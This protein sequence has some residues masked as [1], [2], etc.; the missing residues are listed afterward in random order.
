MSFRLLKNQFTSKYTLVALVVVFALFLW[1][2][3]VFEDD[4]GMTWEEQFVK[5]REKRTIRAIVTGYSS[6]SDE[7]WGDPHITAS[8]WHVAESVVACPPKYPFKTQVLIEGR[9]YIC[10]DRMNRRYWNEERWDVWHRSK[11]EALAW[12]KKELDII[13]ISQ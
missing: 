4:L 9:R 13:I 8:G 1:I 11:V 5:I 3:G 6:S 2:S 7:T 12:G 10:M